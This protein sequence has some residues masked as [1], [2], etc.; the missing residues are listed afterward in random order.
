MAGSEEMKDMIREEI[1]SITSLE[2]R[3]AFKDLM[4]G[5]FLSLYEANERMYQE[6]EQRVMDD[7][8]YDIN[9][10]LI[11][12]GLVEKA[13]LDQSD[14]LMSAMCPEDLQEHSY[15]ISEIKEAIE[16]KGEFRIATVLLQCDAMEIQKI[17]DRQEM[18]SGILK[19]EEE[20]P[21][22]ISLKRCTRY[23]DKI[24]HL[25]HLFMKNGIP[26]K[27]VNAPYLFK[28]ADV[29]IT[30]LPQEAVSGATVTDLRTDFGEYNELVHYEMIP[31]W[32]VGHLKLD[33]IGFPI[34]CGDH[35]NYEHIMSIKN[36][37]TEHVYL[38]DEQAGI[39]HVRQSGEKLLVTGEVS[40]VKK[41]DVFVIRGGNGSKL[42]RHTYPIMENLRKDSFSERFRQRTNQGVKTKAELERFIRGFGLDHMI[43]YQDCHLAEIG[44]SQIETYSMNFFMKDEIRD[45]SKGKALVLLFKAKGSESWIL[46]DLASFIASEVQE[47][48]PEYWCGGKLV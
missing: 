29:C 6:L 47:L 12:T 23:L 42:D 44:E 2:E 22:S 1:R 24:E 39:R 5:V 8:A 43:E 46:R 37:G 30:G 19:A 27:T 26:W 33:S 21:V 7:L 28:M 41:W 9:L 45:G 14:R 34:P 38:V 48:Y 36:Y 11:R 31:I 3:V 32:N 10:Y 15:K 16:T 17:F 35:K 20:Y 13:Y 25:Y 40:S 4:E 18:F